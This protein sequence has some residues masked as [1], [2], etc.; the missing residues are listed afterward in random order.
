MTRYAGN[1]CASINRQKALDFFTFLHFWTGM[2]HLP[3]LKDEVGY[4]QI[5]FEVF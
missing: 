4:F 2:K 5:H 3:Q 1:H